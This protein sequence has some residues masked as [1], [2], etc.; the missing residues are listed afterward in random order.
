M[1]NNTHKI[2]KQVLKSLDDFDFIS[3]DE[4]PNI[5]LYMDQVTTFMEQHL[6]G[7]RRYAE[8][9]ILTKTMINNYAKNDLLPPPVKKKYSREHLLLLI[10]IY[11]FKNIISIADIDKLFTPITNEHFN[12]NQQSLEDIY[13]AIFELERAQAERLAGDVVEKFQI[14][15]S[16]F[17]DIEDDEADY[18]HSFALI[19][20]LSFDV[21][22]KKVMI[23][24]LID[25]LPDVETS[26]KNTKSKKKKDR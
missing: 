2:V 15:Q 19:C 16:T 20:L 9:K 5:D 1:K 8:D 11:Y 14:A 21:Y 25:Q 23:E 3:P 18:L 10:F 17:P 22:L 24:R 12:K 26:K 13:N 6:G 4:I 7:S